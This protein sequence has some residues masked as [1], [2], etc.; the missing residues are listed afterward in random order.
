V[1]GYCIIDISIEVGSLLSFEFRA[2][3]LQ[4]E[5]WLHHEAAELTYSLILQ[6]NIAFQSPDRLITSTTRPIEEVQLYFG[7]IMISFSSPVSF[8]NAIDILFEFDCL[9]LVVC[10]RPWPQSW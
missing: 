7:V 6:L 4:C 8:S 2:K 10:L 3:L 9:L 1:N 5:E